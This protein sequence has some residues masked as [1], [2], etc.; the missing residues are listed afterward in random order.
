MSESQAAS[1]VVPDRIYEVQGVFPSDATLQEAIAQLGQAGYDRAD[2][3]LPDVD[4]APSEA[5]PEGSAENP[6]TDADKRQVRT[7][8]V[9]IA[10]FVGAA[11]AA[12]AAVASGGTLVPAIAAA[13][14]G[15]GAAVAAGETIG[16]AADAAQVAERDQKGREG[17]LVLAC[18]TSSREQGEQ[19]EQIMQ[20]AGATRVVPVMREDQAVTGGVN[21]GGWT[22]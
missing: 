10:G 19:V 13:A 15:G 1:P 11:A 7:N 17:R 18:R 4:P 5:T 20:A 3:S 2:M 6:T 14:L 9:G 16:V 8:F 12:G 22:G 21:A